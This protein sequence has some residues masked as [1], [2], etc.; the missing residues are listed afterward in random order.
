VSWQDD[1]DTVPCPQCGRD[2][3]EDAE[4]C[5]SCGL[6]LTR[7]EGPLRQSWTFRILAIICLIVA[8]AWAFTLL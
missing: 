4:R 3:Y 2:V 6:Y 5:P 8:L 1:T 7:E